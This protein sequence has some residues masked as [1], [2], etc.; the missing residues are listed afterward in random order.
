[1]D[2]QRCRKQNTNKQIKM[3]ILLG[4]YRSYEQFSYY[5][6]TMLN[7]KNKPKLQDPSLPKQKQGL[8]GSHFHDKIR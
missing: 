8:P 5:N 1:M 6:K 7:Y 2:T 4:I 3:E